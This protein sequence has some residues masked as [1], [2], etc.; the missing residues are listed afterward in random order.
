MVDLVDP[1][2]FGYVVE[3][4][5]VEPPDYSGTV[6]GV[7]GR[8]EFRYMTFAAICKDYVYLIHDCPF[9]LVY[10]VSLGL[11]PAGGR[12]YCPAG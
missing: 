6:C 9:L 7:L 4:S 11:S 10:F 12:F 2:Y 8:E 1:Y 3:F 5:L